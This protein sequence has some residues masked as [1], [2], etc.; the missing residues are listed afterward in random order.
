MN[1]FTRYA[2][3]IQDYIY[4]SGWQALRSVQNA[5]AEARLMILLPLPIR[6]RES[7]I[8]RVNALQLRSIISGCSFLFSDAISEKEPDFPKP[9]ALTSM[10]ISGFLS[11][12]SL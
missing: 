11:F 4:Q 3:F 1:V 12:S 5:A 6:G 10:R 2:P 7:W 9:A 8:M